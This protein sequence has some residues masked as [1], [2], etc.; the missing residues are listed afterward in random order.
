MT[1]FQTPNKLLVVGFTLMLLS[2][3]PTHLAHALGIA[4]SLVLGAWAIDEITSGVN[5][6]RRVL[7]AVVLI[8][9]FFGLLAK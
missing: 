2:K 4:A 7:G 6:F 5:W 1:L 8:A 3:L 9:I